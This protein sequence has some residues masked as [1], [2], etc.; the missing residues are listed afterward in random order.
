MDE[1]I[2]Y[3]VYIKTDADGNI[4]DI[5]SNVFIADTYSWIKIDEGTGDKYAHAQGMYLSDSLTNE[6]GIYRYKY[7]DNA[8]VEKTA[9][10][11]QSEESKIKIP[12]SETE[13]LQKR[14]DALSEEND[15]LSDCLVEMAQVV[16]A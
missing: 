4:T 1:D 12:L 9:E 5:N 6:S 13:L 11:I 15:F 3:S 16:Y 2:I 8:V 7:I 14:I 10:E